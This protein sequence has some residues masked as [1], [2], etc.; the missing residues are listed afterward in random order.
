MATRREER[1][2]K[3]QRAKSHMNLT[4]RGQ[5]LSPE[6]IY[7]LTTNQMDWGIEGYL[8]PRQYFD[9]NQQMWHKR[10]K[11]I[12]DKGKHE[13]PPKDWPKDKNNEDK[14]VPPKRTSYLDELDKWCKSYYDPKRAQELI[15]EKNINVKDYEPKKN[16]DKEKRQNFLNH[17]KERNEWRKS[18]PPYPEYKEEAISAVKEK[19]EEQNKEKKLTFIEKMKLRYTKERPQTARCDRISPLADAEFVGEQIPFYNSPPNDDED[20]K[21][22]KL[23]YPDKTC[24]WRRAPAWKYPQPLYPDKS[25]FDERNNQI[26]EK[27]QE[28]LDSKGLTEKDLNI[29]LMD[30]FLKTK[31]HGRLLKK[32]HPRF[33]YEEEEHYVAAQENKPKTFVGPQHYWRMPKE[34]NNL[35]KKVNFETIED[36]KGNKIHYMDRRKTDK[37]IYKSGM[38][39]SVY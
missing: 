17:E 6:E 27:R 2:M 3:L 37:R 20:T 36:D 21:K 16:I 26:K 38:R 33:K 39:T 28:Y 35:K 12:L 7:K 1:E 31:N 32:I 14:K 19:L 30:T 23:F 11:E 29:Q 18:R 15:E 25:M 9:Y 13:W 8:C 34:D 4:V 10:R 5:K 22:K 24:T